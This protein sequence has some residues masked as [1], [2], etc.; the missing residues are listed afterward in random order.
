MN[1]DRITHLVINWI[2]ID[3]NVILV[4]ATDN[5]RWKWDTEVGM[6]GVDAKTIVYVTLTDNG[7]GYSIS[8]DGFYCVRR[9][10]TTRSH[11]FFA[12]I[13]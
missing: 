9:S 8:E 7:P 12:G 10:R 2:S 5:L 1:N 13:V 3:D 6:S 11:G 4:G